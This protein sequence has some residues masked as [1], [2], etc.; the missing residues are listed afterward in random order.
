M[1]FI[2]LEGERIILFPLEM[3]HI[4]ELYLSAKHPEIWSF[5]PTKVNSAKDMEEFVRSA[6][7]GKERVEEFP[8]VVFDKHLDKVVGMT[9]FLRIS[10][11]NKNLNIG[12]TWYSPEVWRTKVNTECK[13]LLLEYAFEQWHAVRVELIT[14]INHIRSQKAIER[15]GA[16]K[17]G[18]LRKKYNGKD[19][20]FY[21]IIDDDWK[22]VKKLLLSL[23]E[24]EKCKK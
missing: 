24:N 6:I 11:S 4:K 22:A 19:Y 16:K 20:V 1:N 13:Y 2:K 9:R 12:W 3:A 18:V 8:Y 7:Q 15:I 14:T 23:L 5:L 10:E 21:S 17:E